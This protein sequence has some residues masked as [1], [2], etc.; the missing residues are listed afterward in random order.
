M[1]TV[2]SAEIARRA[3][4]EARTQKRI[5][6]QNRRKELQ[7]FKIQALAEL[8]EWMTI[9]QAAELLTVSNQR[10]DQLIVAGRLKF[11]WTPYGRVVWRDDIKN[12]DMTRR[13]WSWSLLQIAAKTAS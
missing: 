2:E 7:R 8:D 5:G 3:G 11:Q 6:K 4:V 9:G 13:E 1:E 10:V 12:Y